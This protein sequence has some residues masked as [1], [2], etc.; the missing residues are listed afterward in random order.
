[1]KI[2]QLLE[3]QIHNWWLLIENAKIDFLEKQFGAKLQQL[4]H[5]SAAQGQT[6]QQI[7]EKLTEADPTPNN[8]FLQFIVKMYV[9]GLFRLEDTNRLKGTLTLFNKVAP[10]L[11]VDQRNILNYTSLS[12]LYKV[13]KP[14]EDNPTDIQSNKQTKAQIKQQGANVIIDSPNFKVISPTTEAAACFYGK[15]TKWC[16]TGD[17][18]NQFEHYNSQGSIYIIM[19]GDRKFQLHMETD[20]F[21]DEEDV[22]IS[23]TDD[24]E[25][26][27]QI[28]EYKKFLEW[29]IDKYYIN[30]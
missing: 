7:I 6:P 27:S 4:T 28:P 19:T 22:D 10:K 30:G 29:L 23:E 13:L 14:F 18:D 20:Q 15:G 21:M 26:L 24:I 16:T 1:M 9:A 5:D 2:K 11:P 12:Q 25:L 3:S 8:K 17:N